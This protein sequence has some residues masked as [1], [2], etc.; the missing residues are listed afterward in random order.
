MNWCRAAK[1]GGQHFIIAEFSYETEPFKNESN[2]NEE[3]YE[4]YQATDWRNSDW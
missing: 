3:T 1:I 4:D 2:I